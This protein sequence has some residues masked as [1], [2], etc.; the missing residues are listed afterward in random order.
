MAFL[1]KKKPSELCKSLLKQVLILQAE[2]ATEEKSK[3]ADEK[4]QAL[5]MQMRTMLYGD[6]EIEPKITNI[7]KLRDELTNECDL[8]LVLLKAM[9]HFDLKTQKELVKIFA[10]FLRR[11]RQNAFVDYFASHPEIFELLMKSYDDPRIAVHCG[12]IIR[13]CI[14]HRE[15]CAIL[16]DIKYLKQLFGLVQQTGADLASDAFITLRKLLLEH[17]SLAGKFMD[18]NYSVLFDDYFV[19]L[20]RSDN[21]VTRKKALSLLHDI[22]L[23]KKNQKLLFIYVSDVEHLKLIMNMLR[24]KKVVLQFAVFDVF[25]L[26]VA[27]TR[28]TSAIITIL[29]KNREILKGFLEKLEKEGNAEFDADKEFLNEQ[30]DNLQAIPLEVEVE[31][32]S[33][34]KSSQHLPETVSIS[35]DGDIT[36]SLE[37]KQSPPSMSS[38]PRN[39]SSEEAQSDR[40]KTPKKKK[41]KSS[42]SK[43]KRRSLNP[44]EPDISEEVGE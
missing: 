37:A 33:E 32:E 8:L 5:L 21:F 15:L 29:L 36:N 25:K 7:Q 31:D 2:N 11:G 30:L 26:F 12:P 44:K 42:K 24:I 23:E 16:L 3:K 10:F 43:S 38:E 35:S 1:F 14:I 28:K 40:V 41:K 17:K 4:V 9:P 18:A 34:S 13:E 39:E 27:N 22:L 20:L 19:T 6:D